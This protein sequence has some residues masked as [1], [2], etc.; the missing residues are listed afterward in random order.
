MD[1]SSS[2]QPTG[3]RRRTGSGT[4]GTRNQTEV[5][6]WRRVAPTCHHHPLIRQSSLSSRFVVVQCWMALILLASL[7]HHMASGL[8]ISMLDIPSPVLVGE[9]VELA[10]SYDLEDDTLYSVKWYKN[11]VEF[12]RYVPKDW[13]PG[14]FLPMPGVKV[15]VSFTIIENFSRDH[16]FQYFNK[17][18]LDYSSHDPAKGSST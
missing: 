6:M 17:L 11:D 18:R 13:P 4:S 7:H 16:M 10:C 12:Y 14:Q 3:R 1:T 2:S 8:R 5:Q 15:D 9:S